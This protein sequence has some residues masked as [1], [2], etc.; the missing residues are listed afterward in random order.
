MYQLVVCLICAII[1][2][3]STV[4]T[5]DFENAQKIGLGVFEMCNPDLFF[6]FNLN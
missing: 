2:C 5:N 4:K 3:S 1:I 6:T